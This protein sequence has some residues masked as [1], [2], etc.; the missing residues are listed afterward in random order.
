MAS[1]PIPPPSLPPWGVAAPGVRSFQ[2]ALAL[3]PSAAMARADSLEALA[4]LAMEVRQEASILAP[5][6]V[7]DLPKSEYTLSAIRRTC[8]RLSTSTL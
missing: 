3:C 4:M 2:A 8:L 1:N 6:V 7:K 5:A